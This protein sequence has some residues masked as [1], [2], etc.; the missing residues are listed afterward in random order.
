MRK[1]LTGLGAAAVLA[2]LAS[3]TQAD[4]FDGHVTASAPSE[5][6]IAMSTYDGTPPVVEEE[7]ADAEARACPAGA[8]DCEPAGE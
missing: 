2:L 4:C 5:E 8:A 1:L 3:A 7:K 6:K